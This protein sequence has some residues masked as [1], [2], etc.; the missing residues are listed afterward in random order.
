MRA[1]ALV[2]LLLPLAGC[3]L[4]DEPGPRDVEGRTDGYA[5]T[6]A[7]VKVFVQEEDGTLVWVDFDRRDW[8]AAELVRRLDGHQVP[9]LSVAGHE[10]QTPGEVLVLEVR[11]PAELSQLRYDA[12]AVTP[13]ERALMDLEYEEL[14][15]SFEGG[16]PAP[17]STIPTLPLA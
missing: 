16:A 5:P 1:I 12:M 14:L 15:A 6:S 4:V 11:D 10:R 9:Y 13:R 7:F 17:G 3:T 2:A 8:Y